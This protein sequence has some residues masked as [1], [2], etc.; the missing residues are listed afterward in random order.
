ML[1][2]DCLSD[3][4][5]GEDVV[6]SCQST[7]MPEVDLVLASCYLMVRG[8]NMKTHLLQGKHD[9]FPGCFPFVYGRKVEVPASV[10]GFHNGIPVGIHLEQEKLRFGSHVQGKPQ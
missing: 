6:C 9:R 1:L 2:S 4:F 3:R 7:V 8:L 5:E 10:V